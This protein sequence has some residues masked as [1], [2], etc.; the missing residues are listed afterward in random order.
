MKVFNNKNLRNVIA[1]GPTIHYP[2]LWRLEFV[3]LYIIIFSWLFLPLHFLT[4][5][6][7]WTFCDI[8][9]TP[10]LYH[11]AILDTKLHKSILNMT[12][13]P[14]IHNNRICLVIKNWCMLLNI[15]SVIHYKKQKQKSWMLLSLPKE[16]I[17]HFLGIMM[18]VLTPRT[19]E[20]SLQRAPKS[21]TMTTGICCFT[22][23]Y[24][25]MTIFYLF[26]S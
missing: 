1:E 18:K 25:V 24:I 12:W 22:Y 17:A 26:I 20:M 10:S 5:S 11:S 4:F 8:T 19:L 9:S 21:C 3:V 23:Y 16:E 6:T 13:T 15:V 14:K 2:V 7:S